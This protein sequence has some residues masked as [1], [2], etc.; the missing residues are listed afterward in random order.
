MVDNNE[1][2][3]DEHQVRYFLKAIFG[4]NI[5]TRKG[6]IFLANHIVSLGDKLLRI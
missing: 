6:Y 2:A 1:L 3:D 4:S 5:F